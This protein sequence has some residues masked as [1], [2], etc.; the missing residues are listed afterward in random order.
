VP[1]NH[2]NG[3]ELRREG[4]SSFEFLGSGFIRADLRDLRSDCFWIGKNRAGAESNCAGETAGAGW[5]QSA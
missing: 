4:S 3:R 2:A 5:S 1:A